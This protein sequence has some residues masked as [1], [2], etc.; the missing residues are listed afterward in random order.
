MTPLQVHSKREVLSRQMD[1]LEK[2][3]DRLQAACHHLNVVKTYKGNTG[4][5]DPSADSYWIEFK[6]PDC[7]KRWNED[8]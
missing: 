1:R 7:G 6:C 8:Q 2:A 5:Y 4:N 3:L